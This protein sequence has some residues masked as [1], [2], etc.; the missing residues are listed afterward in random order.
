MK[1]YNDMNSEEL[2]EFYKWRIQNRW[3]TRRRGTWEQTFEQGTCVS[4]R[5]YKKYHMKTTEQLLELFFKEKV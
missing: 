2:K 5:T 1:D 4:Y 3:F